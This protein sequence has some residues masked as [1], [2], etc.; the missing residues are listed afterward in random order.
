MTKRSWS[1][2]V[3]TLGV[4]VALGATPTLAAKGGNGGGKPGG[5]GG[6]EAGPAEIAVTVAKKRGGYD[7]A[8]MDANGEGLTTVAAGVGDFTMR[9][10]WSPGGTQLAFIGN[11]QGYGIYVIDADGS[12]LTKVASTTFGYTTNVAWSPAA[13]DDGAHWIVFD[14]DGGGSTYGNQDLYLVKPDGTSRTRLTATTDISESNAVWSP[15]AN[16]LA[17]VETIHATNA[18]SADVAALT[19]VSGTLTLGTRTSATNVSGGPLAGRPVY[20]LDWA[21]DADVLAVAAVPLGQT[22]ADIWVIDLASPADAE[23]VTSTSGT[24]ERHPSWSPDDSEIAYWVPGRKSAVR[25][26]SA[27]GGSATTLSQGTTA[28]AW[29]R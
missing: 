18:T 6:S 29:K 26:V 16:R 17:F 19:S 2:A 13:A 8:V 15:T 1:Q 10:C 7:L 28:P 22:D 4:A 21:R 20:A 12:N 14:D 25:V 5:G 3:W 23:N 27:T 9:S 24:E 11:V